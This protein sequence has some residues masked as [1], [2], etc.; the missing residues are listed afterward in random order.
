MRGTRWQVSQ[1]T[2]H[3]SFDNW[4]LTIRVQDMDLYLWKLTTLSP[5]VAIKPDDGGRSQM[6]AWGDLVHQVIIDVCLP[7]HSCWLEL[8]LNYSSIGRYKT[9]CTQIKTL[10]PSH[11]QLHQNPSPK[12]WTKTHTASFFTQASRIS[13]STKKYPHTERLPTR[14]TPEGT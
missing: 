6:V 7:R 5:H 10:T 14:R 3:S 2:T 11:I 9:T 8:R 1:C 12:T 4:F 13:K